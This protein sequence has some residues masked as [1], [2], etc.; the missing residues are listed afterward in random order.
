MM[1]LLQILI[2]GGSCVAFFVTMY[3]SV[4]GFAALLSHFGAYKVRRYHINFTT[5]STLNLAVDSPSEF[6]LA[7]NGAVL[8]GHVRVQV[9]VTALLVIWCGISLARSFVPVRYPLAEQPAPTS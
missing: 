6:H 9:V 1:K 7:M 5:I 3:W 4:C 2:T 8:S